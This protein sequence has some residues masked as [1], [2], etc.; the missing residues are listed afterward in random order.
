MVLIT[1]TR[2]S[3]TGGNPPQQIRPSSMDPRLRED[4]TN[5]AF[6]WLIF[7]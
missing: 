5:F 7:Q 2:H 4:D 1:H 6:T 3:R